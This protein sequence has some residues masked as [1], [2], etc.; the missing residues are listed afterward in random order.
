MVQRT[1][2]VVS[3]EGEYRIVQTVSEARHKIVRTVSNELMMIAFV[4]L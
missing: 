1:I 4:L 3:Y 2:R